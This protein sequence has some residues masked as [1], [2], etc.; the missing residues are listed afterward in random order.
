M[1][2]RSRR[3]F[4]LIEL[5]VVIAIIAILIALLVPAVQKVRAAALLTQCRN[6][7]HNIVIACHNLNG[8]FKKLPPSQGWFPG[9]AP[10][11]HAGYGPLHFHL[12]PYIEQK[13][14]YDSSLL[15]GPNLYGD[16][17]GGPYYSVE[18]NLGQP[19]FVGATMI[20]VYL[21]PADSSNPAGGGPFQNPVAAALDA[22]NAGYTYAPTNYAYN[23]QVFGLPYNFGVAP[24]PLT[25][26]TITDGTSNTIFFGERLVF[27]DGTNIAL[28]AAQR[29][30][31]W[32]WSEPGGMSGNAQYPM[33][34]EY[35][36][37]TGQGPGLGVPQINPPTGSC[38][39]TLLQS[40]HSA[41]MVAGM[42]DGGVRM[43]G[44]SVSLATWRALETPNSGDA[45]GSDWD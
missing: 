21:C 29:G 15:T 10:A 26:E 13:P 20:D 23:S 5:L 34:T 31:F 22:A 19:N 8:D 38:D 4:T 32:A 7:M 41:G 37:Q 40:P 16:N 45:I 25:F 36:A 17:P 44:P 14:L 28:D 2:G 6:N 18:A 43:V 39:Y 27:C 33:F 9:T 42:G 1:A 30:C 12:L 3:G 35:W 11:Q 24:A